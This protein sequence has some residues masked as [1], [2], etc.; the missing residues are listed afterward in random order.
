MKNIM[1]Y[2][3]VGLVALALSIAVA[4][5]QTHQL[6]SAE[7][8][9]GRNI[10][11]AYIAAASAQV[12]VNRERFLKE[13]VPF[14]TLY[15]SGLKEARLLPAD[16]PETLGDKAVCLTLRRNYADESEIIV[17]AGIRHDSGAPA[18]DGIRQVP[19]CEWRE[20]LAYY[21]RKIDLRYP[22]LL[23]RDAD[24]PPTPRPFQLD[25]R[26]G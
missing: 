18:A 25:Q 2:G 5:I 7:D 10:A 21:S 22:D 17:Y 3:S 12:Q 1:Y 8:Q 26:R 16:F 24:A 20:G 19:A 4:V 13:E 14:V 15:I 9:H 6:A 11:A 23:K